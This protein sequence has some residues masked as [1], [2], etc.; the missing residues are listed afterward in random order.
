MEKEIEG[1]TSKH[2]GKLLTILSGRY[3]IPDDAQ[4]CIK[5]QF[6]MMQHDIKCLVK[7]EN[8]EKN[9]QSLV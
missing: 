5:A 6:R 4:Q 8:G 9:G 7:R 2:I 3:N 1:I